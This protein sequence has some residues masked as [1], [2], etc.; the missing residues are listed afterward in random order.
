M[1]GVGVV[2]AG[3]DCEDEVEVGV[4]EFPQ[5]GK[6]QTTECQVYRRGRPRGGRHSGRAERIHEKDAGLRILPARVAETTNFRE[7]WTRKKRRLS[8]GKG[9]RK[10]VGPWCYGRRRSLLL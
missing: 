3:G 2:V 6:V 7:G 10:A 5:E 9:R 1:G 8:Q 4:C